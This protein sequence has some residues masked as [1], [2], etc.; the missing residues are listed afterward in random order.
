MMKKKKVKLVQGPRNFW[1]INPKTRVHDN[2]I[3]RNK[4]K[5][6]EEGKKIAKDL[7]DS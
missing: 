4:K 3:K 6:R 5:L 7:G 2:D 1:T